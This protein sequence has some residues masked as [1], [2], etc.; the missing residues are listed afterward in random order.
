MMREP[1]AVLLKLVAD[2]PTT[3]QAPFICCEM[4]R[5]GEGF[6]SPVLSCYSS[7]TSLKTLSAFAAGAVAAWTPAGTLQPAESQRTSG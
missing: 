2:K 7:S 1:L 3:N 5:T 4:R 6:P